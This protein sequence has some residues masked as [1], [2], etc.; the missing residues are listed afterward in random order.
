MYS[1]LDTSLPC[2]QG[3][4]SGSSTQTSNKV[5]VV[6]RNITDKQILVETQGT[7]EDA[8]GQGSQQPAIVSEKTSANESENMKEVTSEEN[9]NEM[10]V[11]DAGHTVCDTAD[12]TSST[13]VVAKKD[14][15]IEHVVVQQTVVT[16]TWAEIV[17]NP[18]TSQEKNVV[19]DQSKR[20][21]NDVTGSTDV[22]NTVQAQNDDLMLG[23]ESG[24]PQHV[25]N[26]S[27]SNVG[28]STN[29]SD[30]CINQGKDQFDVSAQFNEI[31]ED[32]GKTDRTEN[33]SFEERMQKPVQQLEEKEK[34]CHKTDLKTEYKET[35]KNSHIPDTSGEGTDVDKIVK[36]KLDTKT[37]GNEQQT[38]KKNSDDG[39]ATK[40]HVQSNLNNTQETVIQNREPAKLKLND[41]VC[42][43]NLNGQS[44]LI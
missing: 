14:E 40:L 10:N 34:E 22:D 33:V 35:N 38:A 7:S 32:L 36:G 25:Q 39:S 43:Y 5:T 42:L 41:K 16:E 21:E 37:S 27:K 31:L 4:D 20:S 2:A 26:D 9:G 24:L 30:L 15:E 3:C 12:V 6:V 11:S 13:P 19:N 17:K 23:G 18:S 44:I 28:K 8:V 29:R 1:F